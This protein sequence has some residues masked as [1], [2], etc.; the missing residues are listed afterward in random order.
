MFYESDYSKHYM[1]KGCVL[2][3]SVVNLVT[4]EKDFKFKTI[5][6]YIQKLFRS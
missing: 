4:K 2:K 6:F 3:I 1:E 5:T